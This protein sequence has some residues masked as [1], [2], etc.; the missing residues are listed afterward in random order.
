M[1]GNDES[2][3]NSPRDW[4]NLFTTLAALLTAAAGLIVAIKNNSDLQQVHVKQK[5]NAEKLDQVLGGMP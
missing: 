5:A 4:A 2:R 3:W 1:G